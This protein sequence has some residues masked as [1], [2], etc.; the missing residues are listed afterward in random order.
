MFSEIRG[1]KWSP[2]KSICC[3]ARGCYWEHSPPPPITLRR[4]LEGT[5]FMEP[6]VKVTCTMRIGSNPNDQCFVSKL[7]KTIFWMVNM[8]DFKYV[9]Y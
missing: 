2:I 4:P 1:H 7:H 3:R 6:T 5:I 8:S 9:Y